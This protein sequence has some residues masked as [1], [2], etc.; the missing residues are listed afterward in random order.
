VDIYALGHI[1]YTLLAGEPYWGEEKQASETLFQLF[2]AIV[3]G[4]R[5]PPVARAA[6]RRGVELPS[7]FDA[8]FAQVCGGRPEDRGGRATAAIDALGAALDTPT[9]TLIEAAAEVAAEGR[10]IGLRT[11]RAHFWVV[12]AALLVSLVLGVLALRGAVTRTGAPRRGPIAG[13]ASGQRIEQLE[14]AI[15]QRSIGD[16]DGAHRLVMAIPDDLRPVD[17]PEFRLIESAWAR[18]K[19]EQV[20]ATRDSA[21]K[22]A[23]LKEIATTET[24][25]AKQRT[26]AVEKIRA[27]DEAGR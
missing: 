16:F 10:G 3:D 14:N 9:A 4:P 25:D 18:W 26:R 20:A 5:E 23:L 13:V 7:G 17:D 27:I 21:Q 22:R 24:V 6:R 12:S 1:A 11:P 15:F 2:L 8:W 19:F